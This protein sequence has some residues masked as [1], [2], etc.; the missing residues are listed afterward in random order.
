MARCCEVRRKLAEELS[1]AARLYA[2]IVA[3]LSMSGI[4]KDDSDHLCAAANEAQKRSETAFVAFEEHLDLHQCFDVKSE[5]KAA[6]VGRK[7]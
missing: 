6:H 2:E 3:S 1:T 4:S 7:S 5:A